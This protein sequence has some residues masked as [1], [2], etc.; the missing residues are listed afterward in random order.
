MDPFARSRDVPPQ[1]SSITFAPPNLHA[2]LPPDVPRYPPDPQPDFDR[3]DQN[4]PFVKGPKRKRLAKA[5]DACHKSKRRCDGTGTLLDPFC[6]LTVLIRIASSQAP[7]SN[8]YFAS[9]KCTYTDASGK[10]VPAPRPFS[11]DRPEGSSDARSG[12]YPPYPDIVASRSPSFSATSVHVNDIAVSTTPSSD[13]DQTSDLRTKRLRT[14]L[15]YMST[16]SATPPRSLAPPLVQHDRTLERDQALTRELVHLFFAYRQPQRMIIHQPSFLAALSHGTVPQHLL[17]AVC[18]VAAPLSSQP[19]LRTSPCRY[20]GEIFAQEAVSLMFDKNH[21]L[22][23]E[24]SL[25][26]A[27][28]LLL[29]QLYDRMG[30]SL[31]VGQHYQLA[32]EIVTKIGI[33]D[34]DSTVLTPHPSPELIDAC[35]ELECA[36]RVFWLIF[37][38][39]CFGWMLY[40]RARLATD[41]Q[42]N[43]RLPIDETSFEVSPLTAIPEFITKPSPSYN[44]ENGRYPVNQLRELE[45]RVGAWTNALPEHVRFTD[46]SLWVHVTQYDTASNM[47]AWCF[48]IMHVIH[49][50]CMFALNLGR[51]R[52]R[53]D[54][55]LDLTWARERLLKIIEALGSKGK[56]SIFLGIAIWPLF[57]YADEPPSQTLLNW[58]SEFEEIWGVRIQDLSQRQM[59]YR[60][61]LRAQ[62][63]PMPPLP[64]AR[65]HATGVSPGPTSPVSRAGSDVSPSLMVQQPY[66]ASHGRMPQDGQFNP[67]SP[68][69]YPEVRV[70]VGY[71]AREKEVRNVV[72][73]VDIDPS[74][75]AVSNTRLQ[76]TSQL[77]VS[78]PSPSQSLPSLKASGLLEWPRPGSTDAGVAPSA[79]QSS[80][81]WQPPAQHIAPPRQPQRDPARSFSAQSSS[82][83]SRPPAPSASSGMP[84]GLQWL[85]HESSVSRPS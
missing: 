62:F 7:C 37:I 2:N 48:F 52:C 84:V 41:S 17:L 12:P 16:P 34:S 31:W 27:Q 46:D 3:S 82:D 55:P 1:P 33:F 68:S 30:K 79:V 75:Q 8:C 13:D 49:C 9:K 24:E 59:G 22:V 71:D 6:A 81:N 76:A 56:L 70:Q 54:M 40:R 58:S 73:D 35:I 63:T 51:Q 78:A 80:G 66:Y 65:V 11:S 47:G 43:L 64:T 67:L 45:A 36:R 21:K 15:G 53:M 85:A 69:S 23:C 60:Q 25:A 57:K 44:C 10:L 26:T 5:C 42:L 38:S 83:G 28:A 4:I 77:P 19:R 72:N 39:D 61:Q 14:S 20:A 74:L 50:S 18:A 32:L 29:L